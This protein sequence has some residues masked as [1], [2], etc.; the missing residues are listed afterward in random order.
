[1]FMVILLQAAFRKVQETGCRFKVNSFKLSAPLAHASM[2]AKV[3][4]AMLRSAVSVKN[5]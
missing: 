5:A 4:S 2:L 1:M 3:V